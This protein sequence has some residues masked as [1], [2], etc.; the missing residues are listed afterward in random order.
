M[1]KVLII[2][3]W[4]VFIYFMIVLLLGGRPM[5]YQDGSKHIAYAGR[6]EDVTDEE[7]MR[8]RRGQA[9]P[10]LGLVGGWILM[11]VAGWPY[12]VEAFRKS[13]DA[14][15]GPVDGKNGPE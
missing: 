11:F 8:V 6:V 15:K 14:A 1:R 9:L 13:R 4:C 3:G 10:T 7:Y 5:E 12:I 2:L